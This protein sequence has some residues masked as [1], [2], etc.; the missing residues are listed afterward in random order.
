[1]KNKTSA[2]KKAVKPKKVKK[3]VPSNLDDPF[4][5]NDPIMGT[6]EEFTKHMMSEL[7]RMFK[8]E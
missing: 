5:L 3:P 6:P 2:P 4:H 8:N 7:E 1:M